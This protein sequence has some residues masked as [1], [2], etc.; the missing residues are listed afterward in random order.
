MRKIA[1]FGLFFLFSVIFNV[2]HASLKGL[3][4][5]V[6][7]GHGGADTG[8]T[9]KDLHE[10]DIALSTALALEEF[11]EA[12]GATVV[13]SRKNDQYLYLASRAN[14][15][16]SKDVEYMVSVHYNAIECTRSANGVLALIY[17]NMCSETGGKLAHSIVPQVTNK[18]GLDTQQYVSET[19]PPCPDKPGIFHGKYTILMETS[20]PAT[21]IEVSFITN[22]DENQRL[23]DPEYLRANGW[24]IYAGV[25][26]FLGEEPLP[27]DGGDNGDAEKCVII[28]VC[29]VMGKPTINFHF[30]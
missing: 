21:L 8:A 27:L 24:A 5:G 29:P 30:E 22:P 15:F 16:N 6:D 19:S 28:K 13:M 18:T 1:A 23:R 3:H 11:L 4:I 26:D 20:M 25:A 14:L 7:P 12:D 17:R 2:T 9:C 10:S